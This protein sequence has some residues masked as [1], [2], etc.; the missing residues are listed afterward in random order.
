VLREI[1]GCKTASQ[2]DWERKQMGVTSRERVMLALTHVEPDRVPLFAPNV[3][4]T[5]APYDERVKRF[6]EDFAFDRFVSLE[7][8]LHHPAQQREL[9]QDI[10]VDGYGCRYEY[11]GVGLPYCI[12]SP[13]AHAE[14]IADVEAFDWPDPEAP[15]LIAK[16]AREKARAAHEQREY[17]TAVSVAALFH[18]YHYLRGFEQWMIDIKLNP[19]VH[20]T[21]ASH[22]YH[23]H[24]TLL[25]RLLDEVGPYADIVTG[26]DDFGWS[27]APYMSPADFRRLIKPYYMDLVGRI[28]GRFPHLRFYLHS[29][30]QI[31]D[32][33]PDLIECGVDVLNPI[34]PL[35]HMDPVRLKRAFGSAL[36]FHGGVDVEHVMPFGT[37]DE[38]RDHVKRVIDV[39]APGGGYWFKAQVISP[40]IPP[41]NVIAAYETALEYGRYDR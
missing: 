24:S 6:L 35:D 7:G 18:Q 27:V 29:H 31:M 37:V 8:L 23:I 33:V 14:T 16:D 41:E 17:V 20:E 30:G 28:K 5:R 9:S 11:R 15:G 19:G 32:L 10:R 26:G 40:V 12:Y 36:C 13:L 38:V 39:L 22:I 1:K 4:D 21:I 25:M 3:M 2:H 34:L